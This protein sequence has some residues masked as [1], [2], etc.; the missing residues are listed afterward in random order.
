MDDPHE[1]SPFMVKLAEW[2]PRLS[3]LEDHLATKPEFYSERLVCAG[4]ML[5]LASLVVDDTVPGS[6][7]HKAAQKAMRTWRRRDGKV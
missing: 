5:A 3:A 7:E 4:L 2:L 1:N 6:P